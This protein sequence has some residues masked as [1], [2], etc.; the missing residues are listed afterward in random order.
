MYFS[1]GN[2]KIMLNLVIYIYYVWSSLC[3]RYV[4]IYNWK[5]I[6]NLAFW[7]KSWDFKCRHWNICGCGFQTWYRGCDTV[8]YAW[9]IDFK[10]DRLSL[11][12]EQRQNS[13]H[14]SSSDY[15]GE[16]RFFMV[17][18]DL[19]QYSLIVITI[20]YQYILILKYICHYN[21]V[22][23]LYLLLSHACRSL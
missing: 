5:H 10:A 7:D 18:P 22:Y 21:S 19:Y 6:N 3:C 9:I 14:A 2:W 12:P 1:C 13:Y 15:D 17:L 11:T 4:W 23:I 16:L 20:G 8:I